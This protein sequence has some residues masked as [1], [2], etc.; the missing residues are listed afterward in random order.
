MKTRRQ[1]VNHVLAALGAG[2]LGC[3]GSSC[4]SQPGADNG[5]VRSPGAPRSDSG[6]PHYLALE[7]SGELA[8]RE[9]ALF[10][11]FKS[12]ELC[13]RKCGV[14][15]LEGEK[16]VC[17]STAQLKVASAGPHFGEEWPLVGRGGSGTIFFSNCNLLC[18]YCQNWEIAHRGQGSFTSH[19][20][21][22]ETM[23]SLQNRG[24]HNI[25]LVTPTHIVP[26]FVRAL[27]IAVNR[28]LT[29]PLVYNTG[30]YDNIEV[31]RMLDGIVDI[32]LP[33]FKY[34]DGALA[35]KYSNEA[36]DYP[37]VARQVI[38]E[39]YRQVG[40]IQTSSLLGVARRGLMLRHLV[41]PHNIAG[42]DRF[43]KWVAKELSPDTYTNLMDQYHPSHR[44]TKYP[45]IN[46]RITKEEWRRA[47][48]WA[49][50][51]ELTRLDS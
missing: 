15:R 1:F 51:A 40:D 32:Y 17:S 48:T 30:G 19:E 49:K 16:G 11:I 18:C 34:Q 41:L 37:E 26:H 9:E 45:Q 7:K 36:T 8:R 4:G 43:V 12:C 14:N 47:L 2:A 29:L 5:L 27:R 35:A 22:A 6:G 42:T 13:P 21:L 28:G 38:K 10:E 20:Q 50:Q 44:A 25:N 33:D 39:M 24:C 3:R 23:I 46:R 31:I